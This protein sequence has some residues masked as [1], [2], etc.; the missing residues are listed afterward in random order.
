MLHSPDCDSGGHP[1]PP[2]SA[3]LS[4]LRVRCQVPMPHEV[5][6]LPHLPQPETVHADGHKWLLQTCVSDSGG[7]VLPACAELTVTLRVRA[8]MPPPHDAEHLVH[9]PKGAT[10]QSTGQGSSE[11]ACVSS[12]CWH[13][14]PPCAACCMMARLRVWLP[15]PHDFEHFDQV[16]KL[17][18]SQWMG[19]CTPPHAAVS[20]LGGHAL[21]PCCGSV[22]TTRTRKCM[23]PPHVFVQSIQLPQFETRQS[24]GHGSPAHEMASTAVGQILPPNCGCETKVRERVAMPL[25]QLLEHAPHGPYVV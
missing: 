20:F 15:P 13:E 3:S 2:L 23:P 10:T 5:L 21:P 19:H 24:S 8:A 9:A 6:H 4:T 12:R 17:V 14:V 1:S 7:H 16:E 11:Q 22:T 25:P 18:C